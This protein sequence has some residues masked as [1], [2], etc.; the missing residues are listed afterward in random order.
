[1]NSTSKS[2]LDGNWCKKK[3]FFIDFH[4]WGWNNYDFIVSACTLSAHFAAFVTATDYVTIYVTHRREIN[5]ENGGMGEET[6]CSPRPYFL[7]CPASHI[8]RHI[9]HLLERYTLEVSVRFRAKISRF[10]AFADGQR[11]RRPGR[12]QRTRQLVKQD[13]F[14]TV[15]NWVCRRPRQHLEI[16]VPR[17]SERRRFASLFMDYSHIFIQLFLTYWS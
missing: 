13:G 3:F 5:G 12:K 9:K 4:F 2:S 10:F 14:S 16:S 15:G 11:W 6:L 17:I 8:C 1:M 7:N